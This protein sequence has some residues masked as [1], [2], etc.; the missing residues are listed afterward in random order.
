LQC[1]TRKRHGLPPQPYEFFLNIQ[2]HVLSNNLGV[3]ALASHKGEKIAGAVYFFLGGRAIY[4]YGASDL[5]QQNLRGSN[6]VM[7]EAIK[8]LA[9][10]GAKSLHLGKTSQH[11]EGLRRFKLHLGAHEE[12]IDYVKFDL[13]Q[14]RFVTDTDAIAGWHNGVFRILPGFLSRAAGRLLYRH[15]A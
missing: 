1:Q 8:W 4:K 12:V 3:I 7:W 2:R 5:T 6:L 11:N 10:K 15:W 14:G 9:G 13:R